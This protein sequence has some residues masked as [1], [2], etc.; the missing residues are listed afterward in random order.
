MPAIPTSRRR[1]ASFAKPKSS[2]FTPLFVS[3][4]L[5]GLR[6]RCTMP[7]RCALSSASAIWIAIRQR[8]VERQRAFGQSIGERLP[9]EVLHDEIVDAVLPPTS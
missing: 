9:V 4:T 5:P 8:L 2:S 6:S 3:M 7:A 1:V